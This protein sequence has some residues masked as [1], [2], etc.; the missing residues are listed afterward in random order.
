MIKHSSLVDILPS[1]VETVSLL[2]NFFLRV[3]SAEQS[4]ISSVMKINRNHISSYSVHT[5]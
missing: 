4:G 1:E 5:F 3:F 2:S